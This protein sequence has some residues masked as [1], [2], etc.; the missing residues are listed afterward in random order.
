MQG[1]SRSMADTSPSKAAVNIGYHALAAAMSV[2]SAGGSVPAVH[3]HDNT[4]TGA[5]AVVRTSV[6]WPAQDG[7]CGRRASCS[8][9]VRE[10]RGG[11]GDAAADRRLGA[12][13]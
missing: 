8:R 3:L 13:R 11:M 5:R 10:P 12:W 6:S 2:V 4:R 1:W 9:A 7:P